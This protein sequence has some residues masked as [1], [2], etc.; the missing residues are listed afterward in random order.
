[1]VHGTDSLITLVI[2][3]HGHLLQLRRYQEEL[4]VA[5]RV[6]I[7]VKATHLGLLGVFIYS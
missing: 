7:V 3:A 1:M 4:G 6:N 2:V 5:Q